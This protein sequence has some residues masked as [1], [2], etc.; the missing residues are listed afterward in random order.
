MIELNKFQFK[1]IRNSHLF[2]SEIENL[3]FNFCEQ[4][5]LILPDDFS[6]RHYEFFRL[7]NPEAF[8]EYLI[9]FLARKKTSDDLIREQIEFQIQQLEK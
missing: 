9:V 5:G 4:N 6:R 8:K 1:I 2:I 3:I 7:Q